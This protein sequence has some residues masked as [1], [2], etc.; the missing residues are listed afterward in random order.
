MPNE[1]ALKKYRTAIGQIT[2]IRGRSCGP[3]STAHSA[4]K[5]VTN[6]NTLCSPRPL[7]GGCMCYSEKGHERSSLNVMTSG[8]R[9]DR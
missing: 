1:R 7:G 3:G 2:W 8:W 9:N 6:K 4:A 5:T